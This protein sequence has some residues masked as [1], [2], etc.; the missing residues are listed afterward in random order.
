LWLADYTHP[1]SRGAVP[2][3]AGNLGLIGGTDQT[4]KPGYASR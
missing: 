1:A 3:H 2:I 4:A